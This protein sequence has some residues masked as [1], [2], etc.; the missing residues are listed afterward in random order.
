MKSR[1]SSLSLYAQSI[2]RIVIVGGENEAGARAKRERFRQNA[3]C[4]A[5]IGRE[6]D[7]VCDGIRF[8]KTQR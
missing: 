4:G 1:A 3:Y 2:D 6:Y 5:C 8:K 7:I